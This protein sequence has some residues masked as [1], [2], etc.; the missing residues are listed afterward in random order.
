MLNN[1]GIASSLVFL[2]PAPFVIWILNRY[3]P[4]LSIIVA[5]VLTIIGN[6]VVYI[7]ARERSFSVN[8]AGTIIHSLAAPFIMAAPTRYSRLWFSD[9]SRTLQA[10]VR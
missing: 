6:W 8:V 7:A 10:L 4:K 3:G 1:L 5:G 9:R 2:V